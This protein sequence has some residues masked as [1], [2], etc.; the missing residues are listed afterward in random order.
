MTFRALFLAG[1]AFLSGCNAQRF[2]MVQ[3]VG[4]LSGYFDHPTSAT[5]SLDEVAPG[6]FTFQTHWERALIVQ[7]RDGL[8]ISDPFNPTFARA[9]RARLEREGLWEPVRA[10]VYSHHH[11]DHVGGAAILEPAEVIAHADV[12]EHWAQ[13]SPR[14]VLPPTRLVSGDTRL[15]F[16][17]RTI[18]LVSIPH[19]HAETHFALHVNEKVLYAPDTLAPGVML[20]GGLP[21]TPLEGYFEDMAKLGALPFDVFVASH[22]GY[23]PKA[24]FDRTVTMLRDLDT[25]GRDVVDERWRD[26]GFH[27]D[28]AELK[29]AF[30]DYYDR[31]HAKY[32]DWHGFDTHIL[33]AFTRVYTAVLLGDSA[34]VGASEPGACHHRAG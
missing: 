14:D 25:I 27:V 23:A 6:V 15:S 2:F 34:P 19:A 17:S 1:L 31:T 22:F 21:A 5:E 9:L 29:A 26:G 18:T 20:L 8:V 12:A 24:E 30:K 3:A 10:V 32:G 13:S 16:G 7:T 28:K 4:S 11:L 33:S